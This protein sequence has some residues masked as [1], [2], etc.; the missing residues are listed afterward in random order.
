M[1]IC[2][3]RVPIGG[4]GEPNIYH[5]LGVI[6]KN[7]GQ[8]RYC[9]DFTWCY[10]WWFIVLGGLLFYSSVPQSYFDIFSYH[11]LLTSPFVPQSYFDDISCCL[12][13]SFPFVL[14][15]SD[16]GIGFFLVYHLYSFHSILFDILFS[17]PFVLKVITSFCSL[18]FGFRRTQYITSIG[19]FYKNM[20]FYLEVV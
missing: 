17:S 13:F 15:Q 19:L 5:D 18:L 3:T 20:G 8:G 16:W 11:I 6:Y 12:L 4:L 2:L 9:E 7:R 14:L 1:S 10:F